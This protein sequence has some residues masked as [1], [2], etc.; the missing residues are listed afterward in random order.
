MYFMVKYIQKFRFTV[1]EMERRYISADRYKKVPRRASRK[2]TVQTNISSS[3]LKNKKMTKKK[4][5][6]KKY[7]VRKDKFTRFVI[8]LLVLIAIAFFARLI[9]IEENEPFIPIFSNNQVKENTESINIAIYDNTS[10]QSNNQ[11]ITELEQYIYP[12]LLKINKDYL[13]EYEIIS[14]ITKINNKEYEIDIINSEE[15]TAVDIK[16]TI[17]N[18]IATKNK[19]YYKVENVEK[20][21]IKTS[22]NI[23]IT[24]KNEDEYFIYNL[25]IPIYKTSEDYGI[26]NVDNSSSESQLK[27]VRKNNANKEYIKYINVFKV[28]SENKAIEMYKED[29]IDIFFGSSTNITKMLGKYEY[30]LKAYNRGESIFLMFNPLSELINEKHIRQIV[31]YSIDRESI[32]T[33]VAGGDAKIID[34]PYI[35]DEEKYKYD[36]YAADNLLLSNG[37]TKNNLYYSK[38]G[39]KLTLNLVV[40]KDDGEKINVANKIKNDLLKA[41]V[42]V[43]INKLSQKEIENIKRTSNYDLLIAT[44]YV[45]ENPN[46]NYLLSGFNLTKEI[47][48]KINVVKQSDIKSIKESIYDLKNALSNDVAI[49]GIY[50][51]NSYIVCR[52]N[53]DIF[54]SINYMSLFSEYFSK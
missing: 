23:Y 40:N 39:K 24:L 16:D 3:N 38:N 30:D 14:N 53:M 35:Y 34:L 7:K 15:I 31:A 4:I 17:D 9:T 2:R 22:N 12:M 20:V 19:Y 33:E 11:V 43:N 1:N 13:V 46:V 48:D 21:E 41:G 45:N 51:K 8:C 50:S 18:I 32:I 27:L 44:V 29:K 52:K 25:N 10:L 49:Y 47:N 28:D 5:S 37:Y 26:Y 54:K 6:N 42:H 36:V